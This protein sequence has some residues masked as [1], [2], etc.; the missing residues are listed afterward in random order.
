MDYL[1]VRVLTCFEALFS[2]LAAAAF[3]CAA[4]CRRDFV[5]RVL[6]LKGYSLPFSFLD[7]FCFGG[8]M[9]LLLLPSSI[10]YGASLGKQMTQSF[11]PDYLD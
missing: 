1:L 6:A 3:F 2:L 7:Y 5:P 10:T 4:G 8:T 11:A 9:M